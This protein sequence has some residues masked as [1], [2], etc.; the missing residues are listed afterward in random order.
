MT[1]VWKEILTSAIWII[2]YFTFFVIFFIFVNAHTKVRKNKGVLTKRYKNDN[3]LGYFGK[4]KVEEI[5]KWIIKSKYK[6]KPVKRIWIPKPGKNTKCLIDVPTHSD[7]IAQ[8]VVREILQAIYELV[9]KE[10]GEKPGSL[11]ATITFKKFISFN[12]KI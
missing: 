6:F 10:Q 11:I 3:I 7:R 5:S 8:E 9:F 12:I 1:D 2:N 4:E